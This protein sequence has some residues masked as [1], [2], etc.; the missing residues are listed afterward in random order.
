[1]AN[2]NK[3]LGAG[4][5]GDLKEG[6]ETEKF[7]SHLKS[8]MKT[9]CIRHTNIHKEKVIKIAVCGGSGS[10]LLDAAK[11][12]KADVFV[13]GDYKYHQFFDA[14]DKIIIADIGHYESEQFTIELFEDILKDKV[15][16]VELIKTIVNTNPVNYC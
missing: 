2:V 6:M 16:G 13:T 11:G 3:Q 9:E 7:L 5:I 4:I 12:N 10:F 1:M 8:S 14:E 15:S